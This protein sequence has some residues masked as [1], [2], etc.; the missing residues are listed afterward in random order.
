[1]ERWEKMIRRE[2]GR[3]SWN[4]VRVGGDVV[5]Y[6]FRFRRRPRPEEERTAGA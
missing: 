3:G 5:L 4:K 1:M 6:R 2:G